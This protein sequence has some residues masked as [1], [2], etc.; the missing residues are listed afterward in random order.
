MPY[1][2]LIPHRLLHFVT[3][4]NILSRLFI[5]GNCGTSATTPFVLTPSGSCQL[6]SRF[7]FP[8]PAS[9]FWRRASSFSRFPH[10]V[11]LFLLLL[12]VFVFFVFFFYD[13][14]YLFSLVSPFQP[15][16]RFGD[17]AFR[18]AGRAAIDL[19]YCLS[20]LSLLVVLLLALFIILSV[21]FLPPFPFQHIIPDQDCV[22]QVCIC[23]GRG[24]ER[25]THRFH[26]SLTNFTHRLHSPTSDFTHRFHSPISLI[27]FTHR[28]HSPI[29]L[30]DSEDMYHPP[31]QGGLICPLGGLTCPLGGLTY[32]LYV[33]VYIYI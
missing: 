19:S 3:F 7:S 13:S 22:T 6:T 9:P 8:F 25:S 31:I 17:S 15:A 18:S 32:P 21:L 23:R 26:I 16:Q 5:R 1:F 10:L 14:F 28:F 30:T 20:L 27:D 24:E 12:F 2:V 33:Y 11:F 29:S 4:Y